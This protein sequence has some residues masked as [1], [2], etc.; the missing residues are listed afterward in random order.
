MQVKAFNSLIFPDNALVFTPFFYPC[1]RNLR[2]KGFCERI[3]KALFLFFLWL[4]VEYEF[5]SFPSISFS[6]VF[7]YKPWLKFAQL[8][9]GFGFGYKKNPL[10]ISGD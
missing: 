5:F 10:K 9:V 1:N 4:K 3:V 6:L 7:C 8:K 2:L